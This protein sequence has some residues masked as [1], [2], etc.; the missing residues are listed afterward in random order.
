[1]ETA[2]K[3][4]LRPFLW[5]FQSVDFYCR[6]RWTRGIQIASACEREIPSLRSLSHHQQTQQH[7]HHHHLSFFYFYSIDFPAAR[8]TTFIPSS[9]CCLL[10]WRHSH[11]PGLKIACCV[12]AL[13]EVPTIIAKQVLLWRPTESRRQKLKT[14]NN[15]QPV[16]PLWF[17]SSSQVAHNAAC[18]S[19]LRTKRADK[20]A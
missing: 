18:R 5:S 3:C 11:D 17:L 19:S 12:Y 15:N 7:H 2:F 4:F 10:T 14:T 8:L 1:M 9:C 20:S 16:Y 6:V 13:K